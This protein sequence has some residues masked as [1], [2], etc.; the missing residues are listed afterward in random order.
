MSSLTWGIA[1]HGDIVQRRAIPALRELRQPIGAIWGRNPA[2]VQAIADRF[3]IDGATTD[4]SRLC[5]E[6]DAVYVATPV[7]THLPLAM[8]AVGAGCHVLLEKPVAGALVGTSGFGGTGGLAGLEGLAVDGAAVELAARE[9]GRLVGVAYYRR[10]AP[11]VRVLR[12]LP[13]IRRVDVR[14]G[15]WFA[16]RASTAT[17]WRTQWGLAGGGVLADAGSHRI[18]LLCHLLGPPATVSARLAARF[19]G[20]AERTAKVRLGWASGAA[21][22]LAASWATFDPVDTLSVRFAGGEVRLDPLDSGRLRWRTGA[23]RIDYRPPAPNQHTALFADFAEAVV[24]ARAPAC[25][26]ADGLLVDTVLQAAERSSVA[27][28]VPVRLAPV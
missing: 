25:P 2:R 1:G 27:G 24:R 3:A 14:F 20:G 17:W 7:A 18:D 13:E 12:G 15:Q 10:L 6:V 23:D 26:L 28:G 21:A 8:A 19:G 4:L 22:H 11:V 9:A 5:A 16:P